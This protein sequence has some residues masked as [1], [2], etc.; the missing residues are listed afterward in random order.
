[1]SALLPKNKKKT[2]PILNTFFTK[3]KTTMLASGLKKR[4]KKLVSVLAAFTLVII[5]RRKVVKNAKNCEN[6][7]N[8]ENSKYLE[9]KLI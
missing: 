7:K 2:F 5:I 9:T 8:N 3:E 4:S 1:M 6:C